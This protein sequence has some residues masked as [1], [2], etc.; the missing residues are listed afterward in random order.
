MST[1]KEVNARVN[2]TVLTSVV[3]S[4]ICYKQI[5]SKNRTAAGK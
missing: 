2:E 1:N 5:V 4:L 3:T